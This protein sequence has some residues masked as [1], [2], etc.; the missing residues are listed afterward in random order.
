MQSHPKSV[1]DCPSLPLSP[2]GGKRHTQTQTQTASHLPFPVVDEHAA[3][4]GGVGVS[5]HLASGECLALHP[6]WLRERCRCDKCT[7]QPSRQPVV[8]V[9]MHSGDGTDG[10]TGVANHRHPV[11]IQAVDIVGDDGRAFDVHFTDGCRQVYEVDTILEEV[12]DP[13]N[14]GVQLGASVK[15][16]PEPKPWPPHNASLQQYS[17]KAISTDESAMASALHDLLESGVVLIKDVPTVENYSLKLLK[18]IGTVRHTNWGPT[19]QVHTG[20][21]GIGEVDDAGQADTAYTEMAIPPHVDNPY[22]NPMPQYQILHC[23]VNHSEGGGNI[24]VDAI[25]VAE[26]IRRQSP[27]A[28]DLL[29]STIVRW[30]YGGGLTPYIHFSPHITLDYRGR[31]SGIVYSNKSGGYAPLMASVETQ[32][33][34]YEAKAMLGRLLMDDRFHLK[35]RLEPGDMIIFSNLR[36]LHARETI[37]KSGERY[38]QGSYIDN[39][40]VTSTYLGLVQGTKKLDALQ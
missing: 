6:Q 31:V 9:F 14:F 1:V 19:F 13:K 38:V 37:T 5:I 18:L 17:C 15:P 40:S 20:V 26:E 7:D 30:E 11:D 24:L 35:H 10:T 23:L 12:A 8:D 22:R 21:P 33:A 39:D 4:G 34:F 28:F 16:L 2:V 27:R 25:A 36:V 32:E 3:S 29:A